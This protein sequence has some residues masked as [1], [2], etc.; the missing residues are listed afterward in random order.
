[1]LYIAQAERGLVPPDYLQHCLATIHRFLRFTHG[2]QWQENF[3]Q[4]AKSK[5]SSAAISNTLSL[6]P[7]ISETTLPLYSPDMLGCVEQVE[8]HEDLKNRLSEALRDSCDRAFL[9]TTSSTRFVSLF[10]PPRRTSSPLKRS[11]LGKALLGLES[12]S[13]YQHQQQHD[14]RWSFAFLFANDKLVAQCPNTDDVLH[15]NDNMAPETLFFIKCLIL[16]LL[17]RNKNSTETQADAQPR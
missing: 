13:Q 15:E 8:L 1:M 17:K 14:P 12:S 3:K 9:T 11:I 7:L 16:E 6:L 10:T 5:L 4:R 2:A